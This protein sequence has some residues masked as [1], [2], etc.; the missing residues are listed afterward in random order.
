MAAV[1]LPICLSIN[2]SINQFADLHIYL[3]FLF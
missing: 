3:N 1:Y 2:L